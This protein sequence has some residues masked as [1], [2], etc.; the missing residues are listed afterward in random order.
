M[1][2]TNFFRPAQ[3]DRFYG[4]LR[5][6]ATLLRDGSGALLRYIETG[7]AELSDEV[8]EIEN[9]GDT[10]LREMISALQDT[11]VTPIDR[12]D[13][14]TL[15]EAIDNMLDYLNNAARELKLFAIRATPEMGEMGKILSDA[16]AHIL[17]AVTSLPKD[18][19]LAID[20]ARA[21]IQSEHRVEDVYRRTIAVLFDNPDLST[22][23]K[24][25]EIYRH[26]SNS[27]DRA[28]AIGRLVLKIVVKL[29]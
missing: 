15:S 26:L 2:L 25:R 23:L 7:D 18:A 14:Y 11:F 22:A 28:E 10:A 27:A 3:A 4:L 21:A 9:R 29:T 8:H 6:H 13:L 19:R 24:R 16:S 20:G 1:W 5:D 17:D 12:G